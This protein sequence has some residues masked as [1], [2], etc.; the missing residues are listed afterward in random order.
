M[1]KLRLGLFGLGIAAATT[2]AAGTV[3]AQS[4]TDALI[5][6]YRHSDRLKSE[7]AYLRSLDEGVAQALSSTRPQLSARFSSSAT[8]SEVL[9]PLATDNWTYSTILTLSA[10]MT[11]WDGGANQL[12]K[13]VAKETVLSAR[14]SLVDVEQQILLQALQA[15]MDMHRDSQFLALAENN[16]V[17]IARQVQAAKDRY[18]VGEVRRTDVSQAE[19]RL[20]GATSNLAL[21][22]GTL[23]ISREAYHVATGAYP[24]VLVPPPPLP[25]LPATLEDAKALAKRNHPAIKRAQHLVKIAELN[26]QRAEASMKP[27]FKVSGNVGLNADQAK[28]D[29]LSLALTG[30]MPLYTGGRLISVHRQSQELVSRARH[31]VQ[32]T[33]L[34]VAQQVTAQWAQLQIARASIIA[35]KEE[36]RASRVTLRGMREE[37][38]LG[39]RTTLDVLDAERE[40]LTAETNLVA[41]QRDEYVAV[42]SLLSSMGLMTVKHLRLGIASYD[43]QKN[44]DKVSDAPGPTERQKML[45]KIFKRAGK[46]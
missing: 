23:E 29:T 36:V 2:I 5:G 28:G 4:L 30:T 39:A 6:A 24:G 17:V 38:R 20:A 32:Q 18:E 15:Y 10:E 31:D 26:V 12:A 9:P 11:V 41:A 13:E 7:Q 16:R 42:Y 1:R 37:A 19:A 21:R 14:L 25:G 35:R 34:L 3:S 45:D 8:Y 43:P 46:K 44:Y 40:M 33:G 27:L 22:Q